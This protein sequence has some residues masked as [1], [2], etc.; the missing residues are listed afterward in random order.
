[1]L[2]VDIRK[3]LSSST[4]SIDFETDGETALIGP[5]GC[6]KSV[7][8][9][10][11]AGIMRPDEG[12]I[13]YNGRTLF[14]S[15]RHIDL[16]PQKRHIGYLFQSYALFPDMTVRQNILAGLRRER[17]RS[18]RER[19]AEDAAE[20]LH[21]A[22]LLDSKP[23]Q[24]SGGEAQ[25]TALARM[26]VSKPDLM[27]FDEPFSALDIYL[28]E[29]IKAQFKAIVESVGKDYIIVTHSMDEAY[30][31]SKSLFV[32]DKGRI[33]RSG[34]SDEVFADPASRR[35]A[36]IMGYRNIADA[37]ADSAGCITIPAWNMRLDDA[38]PDTLA[39]AIMEDGIMIAEDGMA[40]RITGRMELP[41]AMLLQVQPEGGNGTLW[42]RLPAGIETSS[43]EIR[44]AFRPGALKLL[45]AE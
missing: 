36:R 45:S 12:I 6:G 3:K 22:H 9:K 13:E 29:E 10:C 38:A 7:T 23:Y 24:L 31:L 44:I 14:D 32:I 25:R 26:I 39:A 5:S 21:V 18:R 15:S 19:M 27:L 1:M 8:L 34:S 30:S 37:E 43:E 42:M 2:R 20:M 11:I 35:A 41:G 16:P 28:R 33:I 4:L 17:D 40:A